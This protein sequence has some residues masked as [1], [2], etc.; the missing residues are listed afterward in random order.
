MAPKFRGDSD[1]WLDDEGALKKGLSQKKKGS[2][3]AKLP[4]EQA[5]ASV[6]E[7]FP[8]QCRVRLDSGEDDV[9]CSY[10][11]SSVISR[12]LPSGSTKERSPVAVGDRVQVR[13]ASAESAQ[14]VGVCERTNQLAR[15]APDRGESSVHVLVANLDVLVIV[16]A[17]DNPPFSPGLVDRFL[18]AASIEGIETILCVN[19][20]DL[21][22]EQD[23]PPWEIYREIGVSVFELS[24][25]REIAIDS[26]RSALLGRRVA[27]CGHSGVGKTSL[28]RTV[29]GE[30]LGKV[31]D[32]NSATG[33][34]RHTTSAAVMLKGPE[35]SQWIDTPGVR[36]FG[37]FD[38][39]PAELSD[40]FPEIKKAAHS[41]DTSGC[42]HI[43][44]PGCAVRGMERYSSYRRIYE[45][46][47]AGEH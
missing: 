30:S 13:M 19:K 7:V 33:K 31:G 46:L 17:A 40:H 15:P 11:R 42:L 22:S 27:F 36:A 23:R 2:S 29:T 25:K 6:A 9:L 32:I 21:R 34:G 5:N 43:D 44:E 38:V 4:A 20:I 28:L 39:T 26:F 41:C 18:V 1:D 3:S 35:G 37:L 14:I 8:N 12:G 10:K 24:A 16:A 47:A 45:S